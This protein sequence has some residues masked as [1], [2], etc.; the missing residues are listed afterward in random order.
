MKNLWY[1]IFCIAFFAVIL[2][3]VIL[4]PLTDGGLNENR[5]PAPAPQLFTEDGFNYSLPVDTEAFLNDRFAGRTLMIDTYSRLVSSLFNTSANDRV[6]IGRD[7][8]LFFSETIAD[9]DGSST[10][11]DG[12][13]NILVSYLLE[14]NDIAKER[15]QVFLVT[16]I[17]NKNTLFG[18]YMPS[19]Y[20]R[21]DGP[22]N[23][24][25]LYMTEGLDFIDL[26]TLLLETDDISYFKTDS[27]WN[28]YG[29]R[30]AAREIMSVIEEKT[31]VPSGLSLPED[32]IYE[33]GDI[34]GDLA[35]MLF[36]VNPPLESEHFFE[37]AEPAY[38]AIGRYR[39]PDDMHITTESDG[40]S[41][42]V[43]FYRDSFA[44]SLIPYFSNAYS[45]VYYTRQTPLPIDRNEFL[46][47]DVIVFQIVERRLSELLRYLG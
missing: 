45:D 37:D 6:I 15:G 25:R 41:L 24:E 30:I 39:T 36:P 2:A 23:M 32:G 46:E 35:R 12:D 19:R 29:T 40:A 22:S 10:F 16:V 47:A 31:G 9:Y 38:T 21:Y 26:S 44:N 11:N 3:P 14:L 4:I 28:G 13:M 17:P 5:P 34:T 7:G 27:H 8:W 33:L 42:R 18:E 20:K 43:A 1:N